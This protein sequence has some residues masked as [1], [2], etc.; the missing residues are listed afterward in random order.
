M[1]LDRHAETF[2][3]QIISSF[4]VLHQQLDVLSQEQQQR[5][6]TLSRTIAQRT[7]LRMTV[8]GGEEMNP[9]RR[10]DLLTLQLEKAQFENKTVTE[11][12]R[13]MYRFAQESRTHHEQFQQRMRNEAKNMCAYMSEERT[14]VFTETQQK[15]EGLVADLRGQVDSYK[16]EFRAK[17]REIVEIEVKNKRHNNHDE[18]V[19]LC[20]QLELERAKLEQL[21]WKEETRAQDIRVAR[22]TI[23]SGNTR[24]QE[25]CVEVENLKTALADMVKESRNQDVS[26]SGTSWTRSPPRGLTDY[27]SQV[28]AG[29][30]ES[31]MA[32]AMSTQPQ[33]DLMP[34]T[35]AIFSD[36][37]VPPS[38]IHTPAKRP[39]KNESIQTSGSKTNDVSAASICERSSIPSTAPEG[40]VRARR[41]QAAPAPGGGDGGGDDSPK[42]GE[43]RDPLYGEGKDPWT[44]EPINDAV[45]VCAGDWFAAPADGADPALEPSSGTGTR[46]ASSA[47]SSL[48]AGIFSS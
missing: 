39:N 36:V 22:E 13:Y 10:V 4:D 18:V 33:Q 21:T 11:Q 19:Q 17:L 37:E 41:V 29:E 40:V 38:L 31:M 47:F 8:E 5:V 24:H 43:P 45:E 32:L 46:A 1:A 25:M 9:R 28:D 7:K 3:L 2:S 27:I 30:A 35:I 6:Q 44:S 23:L 20:E 42:G 15:Y 34:T 48:G 14:R 26:F 12:A 16:L